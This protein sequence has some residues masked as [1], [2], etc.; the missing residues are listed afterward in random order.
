MSRDS[1]IDHGI[2][3]V[4]PS[5]SLE[6][7]STGTTTGTTTRAGSTKSLISKE[8]DDAVIEVA[9]ERATLPGQLGSDLSRQIRRMFPRRG[10]VKRK[11]LTSI[12]QIRLIVSEDI[13]S[14]IHHQPNRLY[15]LS[16]HHAR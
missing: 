1:D 16:R 4:S 2:T 15:R 11:E 5:F 12:R 13:R 10:L 6:G 7:T 3:P 14:D 9:P 8:K